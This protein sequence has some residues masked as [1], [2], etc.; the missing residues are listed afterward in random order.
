MLRDDA[1]TERSARRRIARVLVRDDGRLLG[2][3]AVDE[4]I[5]AEIVVAIA[6]RIVIDDRAGS[7]AAADAGAGIDALVARTGAS[8]L[9]VGILNALEMAGYRRIAE[10]TG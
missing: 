4:R 7:S 2:A 10:I 6:D 3:V 8:R 1:S 9:A 5:A